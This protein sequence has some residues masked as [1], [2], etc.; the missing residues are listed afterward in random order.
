MRPE[1][2]KNQP[3]ESGHQLLV[4]VLACLFVLSI[5]VPLAWHRQQGMPEAGEPS[6]M[7]DDSTAGHAD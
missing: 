5:T 1:A 3:S 2:R 7:L 6:Y 4:V